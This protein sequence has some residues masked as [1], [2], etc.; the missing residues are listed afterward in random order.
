[1]SDPVADMIKGHF[2]LT[3]RDQLLALWSQSRLLRV[4][5]FVMLLLIGFLS[6]VQIM[7]QMIGVEDSQVS[8][9]FI[10]VG[11]MLLTPALVVLSVWRLSPQQKD[12]TYLIDDERVVLRD[13]VGNEVSSP[14]AQV[15]R[16]QETKSGFVLRIGLAGRWL[17]KRAF[18]P[19]ALVAFRALAHEKLG[20]RARLLG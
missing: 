5:A 17:A 8:T 1:M 13:A 7:D 16:L 2:V 11:A 3:W 6:L 14:W 10:M 4:L 20:D 12:V 18:A 15:K 9:I 19:E